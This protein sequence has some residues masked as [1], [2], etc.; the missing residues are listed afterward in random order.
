MTTL[1]KFKTLSVKEPWAS[2]IFKFGK[3][4]E[5]RSWY[6]PYRGPLLIHASKSVDLYK[7][8]HTTSNCYQTAWNDEQYLLTSSG[9]EG[10]PT[11][12]TDLNINPGHIL[13]LV[14][15]KD[16]IK[17]SRSPWAFTGNYHW[18]LS[19]PIPFNGSYPLRGQL[20]LFDSII[21]LDPSVA[22][23][24]SKYKY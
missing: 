5:N 10:L 18:L 11:L 2:L 21:P 13:G 19:N 22:E 12:F 8:I 3:D 24:L 9:I 20:G 7:D 4:V 15:L 14:W 17:N 1:Y 23:K 6:T 16:C